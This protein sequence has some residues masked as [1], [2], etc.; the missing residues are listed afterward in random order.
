[1]DERK[2]DVKLFGRWFTWQEIFA[3]GI[4]AAA[5]AATITGI[6]GNN[7]PLYLSSILVLLTTF[8]LY[9]F[10]FMHQTEKKLET[11]HTSIATV[12]RLDEQLAG[13]RNALGALGKLELIVEPDD[14]FHYGLLTIQAGKMQGGWDMVRIYAP[15]GLWDPSEA[16]DKWLEALQLELGSKVK[17]IKVGDVRAFRAVYGLPSSKEAFDNYAERRLRLFKETNNTEIHYLPPEDSDHPT[18]A[19]GMGAIIFENRRDQ[20][21]V[22]IFAYVGKATD[23]SFRRSGFVLKDSEAGRLL[24]DWF[25]DQVFEGCSRTRVLRG[26]DPHD[27]GKWVDFEKGMGDIGKDYPQS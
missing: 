19:P 22:V 20:R 8:I 13:L 24:A 14:V 26:R 15:V 25:D 23:E 6:I 2:G 10:Y 16:K 5:I 18:P 4:L 21:Y 1:M 7:I 9:V 12:S 3:Y 17:G 27:R 11:L